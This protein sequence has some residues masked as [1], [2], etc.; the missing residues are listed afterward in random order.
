MALNPFGDSCT[1]TLFIRNTGTLRARISVAMEDLLLLP[2][3]GVARVTEIF[4][5]RECLGQRDSRL[6]HAPGEL[7]SSNRGI[8]YKQLSVEKR[9]PAIS[10]LLTTLQR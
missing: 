4:F 9:V 3:I 10:C 5:W 7:G 1:I 6:R 8:S 2:R